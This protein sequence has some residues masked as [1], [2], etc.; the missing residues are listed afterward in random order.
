MDSVIVCL[1]WWLGLGLGGF[2]SAIEVLERGRGVRGA[3]WG[4]ERIEVDS[5]RMIELGFW[6]IGIVVRGR[7]N[8]LLVINVN[9]ISVT[10]PIG[11]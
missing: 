8:G 2:E 7:G 11:F 4:R 5:G 10:G 6:K 9:C 3:L 1:L